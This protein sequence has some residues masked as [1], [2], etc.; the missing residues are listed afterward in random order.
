[1]QV[2][3]PAAPAAAAP[4]DATKA[5]PAAAAEPATPAERLEYLEDVCARFNSKNRATRDPEEACNL[6]R[7]TYSHS[8][9]GGCA[10]GYQ[11][12]SEEAENLTGGS[13]ITLIDNGEVPVYISRYGRHFLQD[14]QAL[15]DINYNWDDTG[16]SEYGM[17]EKLIIIDMYCK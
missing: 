7:C 3:A 10:I 4:A 12:T 13:I 11:M 8:V 9:N 14:L 17:K 5:A 16:L 1:V 6:A 2:P 15:H